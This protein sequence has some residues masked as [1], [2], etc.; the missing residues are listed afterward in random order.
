MPTNKED[1]A[2]FFDELDTLVEKYKVGIVAAAIKGEDI[3]SS[4]IGYLSGN[5]VDTLLFHLNKNMLV[6]TKMKLKELTM[7]YNGM[8]LSEVIEKMSLKHGITTEELE[9]QLSCVC[10][11]P[12]DLIKKFGNKKLD[13]DQVE[14]LLQITGTKND[15]FVH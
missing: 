9:E 1:L 5:N 3:G 13:I 10:G 4:S 14:Q 2:M 12:V 8:T 15:T 7:E 6:N 11:I